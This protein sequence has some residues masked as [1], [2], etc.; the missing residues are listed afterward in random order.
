[1]SSDL[2]SRPLLD[3]R[4]DA[5]LFIN[6]QPEIDQ[7][8]RTNRSGFNAIVFGERGIG[9]TSFLRRLQYRLR[10]EKVAAIFV[11]GSLPQDA[12]E[13]L[14]LVRY[15][16]AGT[17]T[18]SRS[19][20]PAHMLP[21][22]VSSEPEQLL[23]SVRILER[24]LHDD[25]HRTVLLDNPSPADAH[26]L[27]G[28]LRDELWRL[29]LT[30]AVTA[31]N[32]RRWQYLQPPADAFF[33]HVVDLGP[34]SSQATKALLEKRL[35]KAELKRIDL[36]R[37]IELAKGNPRKLITLARASLEGDGAVGEIEQDRAELQR[38]LAGLGRAASMLVSELEAL[39]PVSAS[40]ERLL[41][42]LGWSRPRAVQVLKQLEEEGIV[43]SSLEITETIGRP[44]KVYNLVQKVLG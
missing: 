14:E 29:P 21:E 18:R 1:M 16:I 9:K 42:R 7:L 6:R 26:T 31:D 28:R 17:R 32:D 35:D 11:D 37:M 20:P 41:K 15:Q 38:R 19:M 33:E 4:P 10:N 27:F 12:L 24:S 25:G 13:I 3:T 36:R 5:A 44:R 39:G 30:W 2:S 43:S 23:R 8:L 34:L 22:E 40:D